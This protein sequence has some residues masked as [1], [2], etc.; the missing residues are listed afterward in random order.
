M[1]DAEFDAMSP[2]EQAEEL[3]GHVVTHDKA[4]QYRRRSIG[5][6]MM[7]GDRCGC[8]ARICQWLEQNQSERL[9]PSRDADREFQD[10]CN[11]I[12]RRPRPKE[13]RV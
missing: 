7:P 11:G 4:E 6:P 13:E 3:F 2:I 12:I 8:F 5:D 1:N 9:R 10:A